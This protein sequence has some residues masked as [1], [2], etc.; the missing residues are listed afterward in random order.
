MITYL[1]I[2]VLA[3]MVIGLFVTIVWLSKLDFMSITAPFVHELADIIGIH[4]GV[5]PEALDSL[6]KTLRRVKGHPVAF[7]LT[8]TLLWPSLVADSVRGAVRVLR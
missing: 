1:L 4:T 2:G 3:W 6:E 8:C 5:G 7:L